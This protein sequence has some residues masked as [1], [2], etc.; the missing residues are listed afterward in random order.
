[1]GIQ[2]N[3]NTNNINAGIGSLSIEDINELDIVGVA[4]ASNFKTGS[5][6]L[7]STGLTVGN[8][9]VHSTGINVGTGA[10]V[11]SPSSNV[12]T[13]GTNSIERLRLKSDGRVVIG[14]SSGTQPSAT[15]GGAMFYGGSYPGDFRIS[16]GAGA[17]GT[18]TGAISIMG[19]NHNASL[20]H[21][22]NYGAQLSLYN[23]NT[24]DGNSTAVSF[25][26]SNGL[27]IARVLGNNVSHSSRTGQ[28]VFMTSN[29]THPEERLRIDSTGAIVKQQFTAT[30][31]YAANNTTQ[32]GYQ[33]QNLSDTTN[34]YAA[35]RLTAGSSSPATAQIASIRTGSGQ[36]DLTFQ[37]ESSNTAFEALRI[38]SGGTIQC[39]TNGVLQAF[40]NN[41][42][43]GHQFISQCSDNNNG[44]EVYQKH[45]STTTRNTFAVYANTGSSASKQLQFAVRGDGNIGIN[46]TNPQQQ[47][48]VHDDTNYQGILING[49]GAP[50]IAFARSTT[51]TGEWSVGIDGTNGGQFVINN[52]NDNSNRKFIVSSSGVT[53]AGTITSGGN[54]TF[55]GDI[56]FNKF[57]PDGTITTTLSSNSS[58]GNYTTIIPL[59]TSGIG[60]LH[61]Y[62][63]SIHWSFNS[64][65]GVPYYCSGAVL[66]QT[67]HSNSNNGTNHPITMLSSC[68]VGGNY[69]LQI[70][71]ITHGSSYPGLQAANMNWTALAG[72]HYIVKYKRIY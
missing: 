62:L 48:H 67:P 25:L 66:W 57:T 34:T 39:G 15:V 56:D 69:H 45:G 72:S 2:I 7:H 9:L 8:A 19:S 11:H 42:V 12:L 54:A 6:N 24:T 13:L 44:F 5:S 35:L 22:N 43:S 38:T 36:N 1:M 26:N 27:A 3:G 60:H 37:L 63:V 29:G 30:N 70:R 58:S 4:T 10:T 23:Y 46:E 28:L 71:N 53:A 16:S 14:N 47:L 21:G 41:S 17:S 61:V 59:N 50:R 32:C 49:N 64:N 65:G 18:T 55:N 68:H 40:I 52:S 33:A 31:T 51:T 20:T